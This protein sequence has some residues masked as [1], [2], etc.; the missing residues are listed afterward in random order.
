MLGK[1][2]DFGKVEWQGQ[3]KDRSI[4]TAVSVALPQLK[5]G[6]YEL[7][8]T[9]TDAATTKSATATLPFTIAE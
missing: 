3:S 5:P 4:D 2:D 7:L 9:L 6:S 1:T 8:L